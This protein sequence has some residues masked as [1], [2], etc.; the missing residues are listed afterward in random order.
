MAGADSGSAVFTVHDVPDPLSYT[1]SSTT[2]V[3]FRTGTTFG[4]WET[5]FFIDNLLNSH[6]TTNYARTFTDSNNP[7]YPPPGAQYNN[8]T[9]RPRTFGITASFRD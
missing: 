2:F 5:S 9:F 7:T 8:F 3:Q 4:A 6:T 1:V